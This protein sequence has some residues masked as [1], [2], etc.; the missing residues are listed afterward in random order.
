MSGETLAGEL[1]ISQSHLSRVEL[2]DTA[3]SAELVDQWTQRCRASPESRREAGEL[4][5][6]VA[7]EFVTW[8]SAL[9]SGLA[10][11]QREAAE[12]EAAAT[13]LSDWMPLLIPGLL[14]TAGYAHY[15]VSSGNPDSDEVAEAVSARMQRQSVLYER[16]KTLRWI[17]GE[18][19]LRWQV[20]PPDVMAAQLDRLSMLAAEAHL[21]LRVL[22][23]DRT[24]PAWHDHAFSIEADRVDGKADL[25]NLELLTG[26][27]NVTEPAEVAEYKK[28]YERLAELA[29]SGTDAVA[30]IRQV[31]AE[32][33]QD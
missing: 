13:T 12:A 30:F 32:P 11:R 24:T 20:A 2:G 29:L 5:E 7:A 8:R 33:R 6:S 3:A 15:L 28:A 21:D 22:P 23:F 16:G 27:V 14:Q 1:R 9:A 26:E 19:A 31:M 25:V 10:A 17:I 4:V 18:A